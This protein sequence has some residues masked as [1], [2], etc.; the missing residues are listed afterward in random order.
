MASVVAY[1][2]AAGYDY[3]GVMVRRLTGDDSDETT[4]V[5][6]LLAERAADG[7]GD[8]EGEMVVM[9]VPIPT[10]PV[11]T[12]AGQQVP[13]ETLAAHATWVKGQKEIDELKTLF[14]QQAEQELLQTMREFHACKQEEGQAE[15]D[16][17][18]KNY[19]MHDMGKT[20]NE[21]HAMLKLHAQILPKND[22]HALHA[23]KAGKV[24]KK[25]KNKNKKPQLA[26]RG[27]NQGKNKSKLAYAPKTK[28][29]PPPKK[30]DPA[31]DSVYHHYGDTS[32]WKWNCPQYVTEL[33]K[34]KK[35][36]QGASTSDCMCLN[37]EV[38]EYELGDLNE[39][40]NY[41]AALLDPKLDKWLNVMNLE[42]QYMKDNEVWDLVD[43]PA[44]GKTICSKW[45]FKKK[46]DMDGADVKSYLGRC[47]AIKDLGEAAYILGTKIYIDR[48]KRL[49]SLCQSAYIEKILKRFFMENSKRRSI[50]MQEILKLSK[51]Q[52]ASKPVELKRMQNVLYASAVGSIMYAVRCTRP[53]VAFA[54]NITSRF[55]QNPEAEYIAVANAFKGAVW[56]RK[57]IYGLRVVP[58]IEEPV[59][60]YCDNTGAITIANESGITKGARHYRAK[61]HYMR[62][63]IEFGDVVIEKVHTYD[64]LTDPF[65]KAFAFPKHSKHTK[66]IG[67]LPASNLM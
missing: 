5:V 45:L 32:H 38:D 56:V 37:I 30:E 29:L 23:I 22:A 40:A 39:P 48:L 28:I 36:P 7:V 21:L 20:V 41:K 2:V 14:A 33:L 27:N 58:T 18:V 4:M 31:K 61:V 34:N 52:S 16:S 8:K 67:M 62:E 9:M 15:Y 35:L 64:N 66:N 54:Q 25:N 11:L 47:F 59:K 3:K 13:L 46:T 43:L 10:T 49:I 53:D 42:M 1:L 57:F 65:T 17:F 55:Q 50:H 19:N 6:V 60:M 63:V 26:V 12:I 24:Q 51:S 44:N